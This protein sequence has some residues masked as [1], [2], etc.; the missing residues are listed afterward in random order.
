MMAGDNEKKSASRPL[1]QC[2]KLRE[3]FLRCGVFKLLP[4]WQHRYVKEAQRNIAF[5]TTHHVKPAGDLTM[6]M[7]D[8]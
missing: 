1:W 4:V 3:L 2:W 7:Y 6:T 8:E 5:S